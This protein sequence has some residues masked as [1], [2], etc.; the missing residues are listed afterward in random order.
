MKFLFGEDFER[1]IDRVRLTLLSVGFLI[2]L[3]YT[4]G[5]FTDRGNF[6][7]SPVLLGCLAVYVVGLILNQKKC[8][9]L[10]A[11]LF[12][13]STQIFM[14]FL[15][16]KSGGLSAPGA[17]WFT[18]LPLIWTFLIG[19]KGLLIGYTGIFIT[20]IYFYINVDTI[21]VPD[22]I[23]VNNF[24]FKSRLENLL[25]FSSFIVIFIYSYT[26]IL[27]H[28]KIEIER[29]TREIS[30]LLRILVHDIS[31]PL[32]VISN[33]IEIIRKKKKFD[34]SHLEIIMESTQRLR[35]MIANVNR[36]FAFSDG[37]AKLRKERVDLRDCI[38]EALNILDIFIVDKKISIKQ[39]YG[40]DCPIVT[41]DKEIFINQVL[42]NILSNAVKFSDPGGQV[43]ISIV[44]TNRTVILD[45]VDEGVGVPPGLIPKLFLA[46]TPTTREGTMG[47]KGTG[48][49]L[50]IVKEI[51]YRHDACIAIY[52][53]PKG[54]HAIPKGTQ[55]HIQI[56]YTGD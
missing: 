20:Y 52:S 6:E 37:K 21:V 8:R 48:F 5:D 50:P 26:K 34:E 2:C 43:L 1:I 16:Y 19:L 41:V 28:S 11:Y 12:L 56:P 55:V 27:A 31:N 13:V 32:S 15:I 45:I 40:T 22:H 33:H 39:E 53:P 9:K 3:Y 7:N 23:S 14:T 4:V 51:I 35:N 44:R 46:E 38:Q 47:E 17:F 24:L 18:I 42:V 29:K 25:M 54:A 10:A 36:L 30:T 49:G